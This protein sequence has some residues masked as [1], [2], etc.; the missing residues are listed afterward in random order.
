M[1]HEA[2]SGVA[3]R[4]LVPSPSSPTVLPFFVYVHNNTQEVEEHKQKRGRAPCLC[5]HKQKRGGRS[6]TYSHVIGVPKEEFCN[7]LL[8]GNYGHI[9]FARVEYTS[10]SVAFIQH[11]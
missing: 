7:L 2:Q 10:D 1:S 5:E 9:L 3:E 8:E 11:G 4:S 6:R